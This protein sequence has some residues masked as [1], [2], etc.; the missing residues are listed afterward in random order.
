MKDTSIFF[1]PDI[2]LKK[3]ENAIRSYAPS[4]QMEDVL[5]LV[6]ATVFGSAKD[7]LIITSDQVF[8]KE[9]AGKPLSSALA[10]STRVNINKKKIL[11][12]NIEFVELVTINNEDLIALGQLIA[13]LSTHTKPPIKK[14]H[15]DDVLEEAVVLAA[16]GNAIKCFDNSSDYIVNAPVMEKNIR[17]IKNYVFLFLLVCGLLT[18]QH[19]LL[20]S[21]RLDEDLMSTLFSTFVLLSLIV[22]G[23]GTLFASQAKFALFTSE[24]DILITGVAIIFNVFN[25]ADWG[26]D[27][28][29]Q[30]AYTGSMFFN[31]L[32]LW[33][34]YG[35]NQ[36]FLKMLIVIPSKVFCVALFII[37]TLLTVLTTMATAQAIKERKYGKAAGIAGASVATGAGTIWIRRFLQRVIRKSPCTTPIVN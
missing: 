32:F 24:F 23:I 26:D 29:A 3:L 21:A 5:V 7:G 2:P 28:I 11:I 33:H 19:Q 17:K 13:E 15:F 16:N 10:P 18:L 36:S 31:G 14:D 27:S 8:T 20:E 6:D 4:A 1:K 9:F 12:N 37:M 30:I 22:G 25:I 34:S 35:S